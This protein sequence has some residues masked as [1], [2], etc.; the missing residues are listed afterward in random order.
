MTGGTPQSFLQNG[1]IISSPTI[2]A[3]IQNNFF[4]NKVKNLVWN[5]PPKEDLPDPLHHLNLAMENWE[6]KDNVETF[7]F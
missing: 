2:L 6:R 4:V 3:E 7:I 1:S 5:L